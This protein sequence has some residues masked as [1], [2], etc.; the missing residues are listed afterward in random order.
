MSQPSL[1]YWFAMG[2][3]YNYLTAMRIEAVAAAEG[4][5]VRFRPFR[6]VSAVTGAT[7][8]PFIEGTAKHRYMWHDIA[9]RAAARGLAITLPVTYPTTA[10]MTANLVAQVAAS[11]GW[12]GPYIRATYPLWFVD[13]KPTGTE[14]NLRPTLAACDQDYD[15]V[16]AKATAPE[17]LAVLDAATAEAKDLG[18]FGIPTFAAGSELF[19][20]DDHLEDAIFWAKTGRLAG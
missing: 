2:S 6:G 11:E 13:G 20:G 19:W 10:L 9:R 15:H 12:A 1:D 3:T 17:T 5:A 18:V 8:L 14:E 7:T 4:V 16:M